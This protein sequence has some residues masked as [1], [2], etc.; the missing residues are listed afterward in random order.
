MTMHM[1]S[2]I[3]SQFEI[4]YKHHLTPSGTDVNTQLYLDRKDINTNGMS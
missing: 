4:A 2:V 1:Q 3:Y